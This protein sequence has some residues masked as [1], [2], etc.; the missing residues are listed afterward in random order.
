MSTASSAGFLCTSP[1]GF[2][3][4]IGRR[5]GAVLGSNFILAKCRFLEFLY[6]SVQLPTRGAVTFT[7]RRCEFRVAPRKGRRA[8]QNVPRLWCIPL[9]PVPLSM[10]WQ[11]RGRRLVFVCLVEAAEQFEQ[12]SFNSGKC[13]R[14]R[15]GAIRSQCWRC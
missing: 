3:L 11:D 1:N 9:L 2:E 4:Q 6:S 13:F 8:E 15:I 14:I 10:L 7:N 5:A 12:S